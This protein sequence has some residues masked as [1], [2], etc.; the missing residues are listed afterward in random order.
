MIFGWLSDSA[1]CQFYYICQ[2]QALLTAFVHILSD[3]AQ[4]GARSAELS[5]AFEAHFL[6]LVS[7]TCQS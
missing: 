2:G 1:S 5:P 6:I 7:L 3:E 4:Q